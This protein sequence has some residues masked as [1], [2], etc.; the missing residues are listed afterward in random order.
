[1]KLSAARSISWRHR[2][3]F[4]AGDEEGCYADQDDCAY[5]EVEVS[6]ERRNLSRV[7]GARGGLHLGVVIAEHFFVALVEAFDALDRAA[8]VPDAVDV[9]ANHVNDRKRC[10]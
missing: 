6:G 9:G 10:S 2:L 8:E 7:A 3:T 1:M 4:T 5:E